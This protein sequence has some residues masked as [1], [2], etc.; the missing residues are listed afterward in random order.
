MICRL[1]KQW[2]P[3]LTSQGRSGQGSMAGKQP[4]GEGS[5]QHP[6]G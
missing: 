6:Q 3:D 4:W 2:D 5:S 1:G